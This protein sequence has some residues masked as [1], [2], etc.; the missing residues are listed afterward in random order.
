[1]PYLNVGCG[2]YNA[3]GWV[4]VDLHAAGPSPDV[5]AD[6]RRLPFPSRVFSRTYA[7]HV[8]EHVPRRLFPDALIELRRVTG[9]DLVIVGPDPD[10]AGQQVPEQMRRG[11]MR[12]A[13]DSHHWLPRAPFIVDWLEWCGM[14]V[15]RPGLDQLRAAG[16]PVPDTGPGQYAIA[17]AR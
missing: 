15:T 13:G 3:R 11:G 4:N 10:A 14:T 17:A 16:W 8:L 12:W 5:A 7:G 1:M 2:E 6:L 9:G